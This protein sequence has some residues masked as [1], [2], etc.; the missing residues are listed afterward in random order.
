MKKLLSLFLIFVLVV[1]FAGCSSKSAKSDFKKPK[2]YTTVIKVSIN[3][4][5]NLYLDAQNKVLAVEPVNKAA[6]EFVKEIDLQENALEKVVSNIVA[7]AKA[8]GFLGKTTTIDFSIIECKSKDI[9]VSD[10][11]SKAN[12][13]ATQSAEELGAEI[14]VNTSVDIKEDEAPASSTDSKENEN[15]EKK[16][17]SDSE[18]EI[19]D[20]EGE[21]THYFLEATCTEPETCTCG[22]TK[23]AP[24]GH[25]WV[26]ATCRVP[27]HCSSCVA[28]EGGTIDHIYDED[29]ICTMCKTTDLNF[30]YPTLL[31]M[32][33]VW[34]SYRQ[35]DE[36]LI[37]M[38]HY[39]KLESDEALP[40]VC[41]ENWYLLPE[42]WPEDMDA[43]TDETDSIVWNGKKY[44][45]IE[46]GILAE[47]YFFEEEDDKITIQNWY[48]SELH[49]IVL[50][51]TAT[52]T[53]EIISVEE[54]CEECLMPN[55][56]ILTFEK[57]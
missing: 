21:H 18:P 31:S 15:S 45:S 5:M 38:E 29:G 43:P 48:C 42:D 4:E 26:D 47:G 6:K 22:A 10:I 50:Q 16:S 41:I 54:N 1:S 7:K 52:N 53:M 17:E 34:V 30:T 20:S 33:G 46:G 27:K 12:K 3:P 11:L 9:D 24:L 2:D 56:S 23:G 35:E 49:S 39:F 19:S 14:T 8:K 57:G 13:A 37:R 44:Y 51:R 32:N 40:Y 28:T 36:Y 55:N 25:K